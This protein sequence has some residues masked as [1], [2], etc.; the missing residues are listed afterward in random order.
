MNEICH[1]GAFI[2]VY[3]CPNHPNE[4]WDVHVVSEEK[5]Y[6]LPCEVKRLQAENKWLKEELTIWLSLGENRVIK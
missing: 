5:P 6:C 1:G 4:R 2:H 3:I